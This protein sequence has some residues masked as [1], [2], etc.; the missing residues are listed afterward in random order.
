VTGRALAAALVLALPA[1]PAAAAPACTG[2]AD[3]A[4]AQRGAA[5]LAQRAP[6]G[7]APGQQ[8]DVIIALRAAGRRPAALRGRAR[9]LAR[10]A[11]AYARTPGAAGKVVLAAVAAGQDPARFGGVD[12]V[13]RIRR[14]YADGRFGVSAFDQS[15]AI[16][17]LR[18]A[19]HRVP[20]G[21]VAAL[22]GTRGTGGWG[23][24]LRRGG[25]DAV[26]STALVLEALAA[27]GV[28]RSDPGVRA[29]VA[30]LARQR[31]ADGGYAA[32][33]GRRPTEANPT[34]L[35]LRARCALGL[36]PAPATRAALR[37]LVARDGHVRFTRTSA[38]SPLIATVDAVPALAGDPLPTGR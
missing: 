21:A 34:A 38:G 10:V 31:A 17:A 26:D 18:A 24:A 3:R 14:S 19:G 37:R 33:G 30:W 11:P 8:A 2:P 29:A 23:F 20:P 22:R 16:L 4:A 5:W 15:L 32:F 6:A 27:A 28:R 12:Y 36:P 25:P 7:M 9:V 35:V 13:G 1:A